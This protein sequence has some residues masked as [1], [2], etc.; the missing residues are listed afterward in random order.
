[1]TMVL[2]TNRQVLPAVGEGTGRVTARFVLS[3]ADQSGVAEAVRTFLRA[4]PARM[5][6]FDQYA[7]ESDATQP[8]GRGRL[9]LRAVCSLDRSC[10]GLPVLRRRFREEV[11]SRFGMEYRIGDASARK[12]VAIFVSRKDHC[13]LD[14]LQSWRRDEL[15]V[16]IG[17]VVSNHRDLA[18]QVSSYGVRY[19]H[20]P[21]VPGGKA[22]AE[23]RRLE[24]LRDRYDLLVLAR[25]MQILSDDFLAQV[26][27]PVINIHHSILP[28]FAGA[29]AYARARQ[30][31]VKLIGAT[32]HYVTEDLDAGPIIEQDAVR[33]SHREGAADLARIGADI[34]RKVLK[35]AVRWHC[36]DRVFV[37]GNSTVVF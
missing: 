2:A 28:A 20:I 14:L 16:E 29:N 1:M 6:E 25:Y 27:M 12:R 10:G 5:I 8:D 35:R 15:P 32:A 37:H 31:G 36:E 33:V 18:D 17:L 21:I 7:T 24:R 9:L 4:L 23:R 30:R 22:E 3:C 19:E 11:A 13:L 34:E 26:G